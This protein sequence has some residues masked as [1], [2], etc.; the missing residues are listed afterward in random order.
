LFCDA[1]YDCRTLLGK[2]AYLDFTVEVVRGLQVQ[3]VL[4]VLI[5]LR[6]QF[7]LLFLLLGYQTLVMRDSGL[8]AFWRMG[9]RSL[10]LGNLNDCANPVSGR[11]AEE[12]RKPRSAA[13][14]QVLPSSVRDASVPTHE[15]LA[16]ELVKRTLLREI[17]HA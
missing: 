13:P 12:I 11:P 17:T 6:L 1:A 8:I 16:Q 3:L 9:V 5:S 7:G 14:R 15:D 10:Q 2:A 4:L